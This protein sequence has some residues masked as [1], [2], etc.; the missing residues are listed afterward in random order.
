[1]ITLTESLELGIGLFVIHRSIPALYWLIRES[2]R[3]LCDELT[4]DSPLRTVSLRS[5]RTILALIVLLLMFNMPIAL[6]EISYIFD[7][8]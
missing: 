6:F 4:R 7:L 2:L 5:S 8:L 1:M 3:K